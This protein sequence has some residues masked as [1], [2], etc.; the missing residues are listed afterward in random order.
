MGISY[1]PMA[2][3]PNYLTA[4]GLGECPSDQNVTNYFL[5]DLAHRRHARDLAPN[6]ALGR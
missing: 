1:S 2:Y 5:K 3:L 6:A 4:N